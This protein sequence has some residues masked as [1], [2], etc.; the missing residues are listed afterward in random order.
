MHLHHLIHTGNLHALHGRIKCKILQQNYK[1]AEQELEFLQEIQSSIGSNADLKFLDALLA[2]NKVCHVMSCIMYHSHHIPCYV[3][4][5]MLSC[6]V[7]SCYA[8]CFM[9]C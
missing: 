7:I 4:A 5:C 9:P 6:H 1:E 8:C 3:K 2:W